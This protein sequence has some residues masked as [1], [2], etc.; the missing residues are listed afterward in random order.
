[1]D[2]QDLWHDNVPVPELPATYG[3]RPGRGVVA[4]V[5]RR[6]T[7][8]PVGHAV[9]YVGRGLIVE[10]TWPRVRVAE[11]PVSDVVWAY[12]QP[13]TAAQRDL[14]VA[15]AFQLVGDGYDLMAYPFFIWS[16]FYA[17]ALKDAAPL[18]RA[19]RFR[20]CSA[21]VA[22]CDAYA[23]APV[24]TLP[25]PNLTEPADLFSLAVASGWFSSHP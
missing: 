15:R 2:L 10:A 1:M 7:R 18:L 22:D 9:F 13:L 12:G 17:A 25:D 8:S 4:A 23:G 14:A 3:L 11:A 5:I 21:V 24:T 19:D 20:V 16:L 6:A